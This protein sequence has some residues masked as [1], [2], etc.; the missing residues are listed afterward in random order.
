[1]TGGRKEATRSTFSIAIDLT[2]VP[3]TVIP[4]G[5]IALNGEYEFE[6]I[7]DVTLDGSG[8]GSVHF[9]SVELGPI[10]AGIGDL[11]TTDRD[12]ETG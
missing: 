3:G 2:G 10:P 11:N 9:Q 1:M 4:E 6:S 7:S 8:I 5:S 12:W